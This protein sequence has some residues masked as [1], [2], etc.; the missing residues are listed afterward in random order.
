MTAKRGRVVNGWLIVDK[1]SGLGSTPVVGRVRRLLDARKLGHGGTLDPLATGLLPIALGEATKCVSYV[2]D[3]PKRYRFTLRWGEA[4]DSDDAQGTVTE[5]SPIRPN[6]AQIEAALPAFTGR[7]EQIPPAF[8]AVKLGGRRAYDLARRKQE[9][10][11]A[12]R[13]VEVEEF[14]LL[15][16]DERADAETL[17]DFASFEVLCGKGTYIRALARDLGVRLGTCAHVTALRRLSVG[18]FCEGHAISLESLEALGHSAAASGWI[19]P[20]EAALDDIPALSLNEAEAGR[21]RCGQA[22]SIS[23]RSSNEAVQALAQGSI[24]VAMEAGKAVGLARLE[25]GDLRP[26]RI[27]NQS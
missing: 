7:I 23:S 2:M 8:S 18:P 17:R 5:Q 15:P 22:V 20:V 21:L 13:S 3:A 19:Y 4:R 12:A 6:R 1:P 11:L 24:V 10:N 9:V 26:V 25:A 27:L 16:P 14:R